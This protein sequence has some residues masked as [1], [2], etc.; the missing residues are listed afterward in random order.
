MRPNTSVK[1]D[2][3]DITS[4]L[5][6]YDSEPKVA[7]Y[8]GYRDMVE[9]RKCLF[10]FHVVEFFNIYSAYCSGRSGKVALE[11][12][13]DLLNPEAQF[14]HTLLKAV[15]IYTVLSKAT[16]IE[17]QK[18]EGKTNINYLMATILY[19][20]SATLQTPPVCTNAQL[21]QRQAATAEGFEAIN[22]QLLP[23]GFDVINIIFPTLGPQSDLGEDTLE[24]YNRTYNLLRSILYSLSPS[25]WKDKYIKGNVDHFHPLI[26]YT[27]AI[28]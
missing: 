9:F 5:S 26:I 1:G 28:P 13:R 17:Q 18:L 10:S 22:K 20:L 2:R 12:I 11:L 25:R 16:S 7:A 27:S 3:L 8:L 14:P 23:I 4:F 15:E 24:T 19:R 21:A 6:C